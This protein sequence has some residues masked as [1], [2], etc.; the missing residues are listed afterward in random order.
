MGGGL[1]CLGLMTDGL[2]T[3]YGVSIISLAALPNV[4]AI[5]AERVSAKDGGLLS[6]GANY[7]DIFRRAAAYVDRILRGA[8]PA[9][10]PVQAPTKFEFVINAKTAKELGLTVPPNLLVLADEVIE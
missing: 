3:F 9:D 7:V 8:T 2:I 5:Y 10:L 4:S 1:V 6:Y